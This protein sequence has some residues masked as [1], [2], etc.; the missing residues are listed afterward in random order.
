MNDDRSRVTPTVPSR[1]AAEFDLAVLLGNLDEIG[2]RMSRDVDVIASVKADA[3]GHGAVPVSR[4]LERA[5]VFAL[6]TGSIGEA[7]QIRRASVATPILIFPGF[8][9]DAIPAVLEHG[10]TP[11]IDRLELAQELSAQAV[12]PVSLWIK[13]DAGLGR[14]GVRPEEV[15]AFAD[16]VRELPRVDLAGVFTHLPFVDEAGRVWAEEGVA[17]FAS[18]LRSLDAQG[19]EVRHSQALSSAGALAG[20]E[21]P[22]SAICPG[23]A[24]YGIAPAAPA[25]M[26]M[27]GLEPVVRSIAG[28]LARVSSHPSARRSGVGGSRELPAG[29]VTGVVSFGR[30]D[31]YRWHADEPAAML[32]RGERA[33]VIGLSLEH[34]MLDLTRVPGARPGDEVLVLGR[35]G[36]ESVTL[37]EL[38]GWRRSTPVETLLDFA[39]RV[40]PQYVGAEPDA[41]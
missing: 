21:D 30:R 38:A 32:V 20:L 26:S 5:G 37:P 29:S 35:Q 9:A 15:V 3:Y 28:V 24:L 34:V 27:D 12:S 1:A 13:V 33:P 11:T 39:G 41:L 22:S 4:A 14:H 36:D 2:R 6:A 40:T 16:A 19:H 7:A 31:G 23:H 8:L 18:L 10:L 25:V 17:D